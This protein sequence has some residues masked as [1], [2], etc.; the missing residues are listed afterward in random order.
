MASLES[1]ANPLERLSVLPTTM[2]LRKN[3]LTGLP[4]WDASIQYYLNDMVISQI[5]GGA[6]VFSGGVAPNEQTTIR[7][8]VDPSA[9]ATGK[10]IKTFPN[11]VSYYDSLNPT[12]ADGGAGAYTI[13]NGSLT[14]PEGSEW[15]V[16]V[17]STTTSVA[18]LVADQVVSWTMTGSGAGGS[19]VQWDVLP[20][21]DATALTTHWSG[22]GYVSV[23]TGA[24]P[25]TLALTGSYAGAVQTATVKVLA[26][27]LF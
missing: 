5:D 8:G 19:A 24:G 1:L 20:R 23:G 12:V 21:A 15:F 14:V 27:R 2:N 4:V 16:S 6:Y 26:I 11:G 7:G 3:P 22:S 17:Q 18:P 9:D 13:T 25:F 10:W